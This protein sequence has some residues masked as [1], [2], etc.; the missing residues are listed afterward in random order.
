[1]SAEEKLVQKCLRI[2]EQQL[3][4]GSGESWHNDVFLELSEE[5]QKKTQVLLSPTTLK[6][7]WGRVKYQSAP[8]VTTLNTL[9]RFAGYTNWRDFKQQQKTKK[10]AGVLKKINPNLGIIMLSA[11]VMTLVFIS[12]F[13]LK[14][15]R[16]GLDELDLSQIPFSSKP[17]AKGLPN[18]VVFD[19]DLSEISSD[20]IHIQQY[21]DPSRTISIKKGQTQA[22]GQYFYPGYF[23][24]KLLVEGRIIKEHDL[25]IKSEGWLGTLNYEPVPKYIDAPFT[26]S[27][28]LGFS[29]DVV[30]EVISNEQPLTTSFH[31][32][33]DF[34]EVSGDNF[35]LQTRA[36]IPYSE[37]WA[38]C[39]NMAILVLGTKSALIV[40]FSIPGCVSEIGLMLSEKYLDGKEH[41]LSALGI[42]LK[43]FRDVRLEVR[44]K[45]LSVYVEEMAVFSEAYE[46]SIGDLAGIR[47]RF[48]GV[49]EVSQMEIQDNAGAVVYDAGPGTFS[50]EAVD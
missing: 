40:N 25:F 31:Y 36:R 42:D 30:K 6:R 47:C 3:G 18:S 8:S 39:Q 13:S 21:W 33:R 10:P 11:S 16:S 28:H 37:K 45:T 5:I 27:G 48:L 43:E 34:G 35:T 12:F 22:T 46:N 7:V 15:S 9:A 41:D 2:I 19:F 49:G 20:S 26:D 29:P 1:M 32:V 38:V 50:E 23:R 44:D 4:W 17:L 24:A 14:G